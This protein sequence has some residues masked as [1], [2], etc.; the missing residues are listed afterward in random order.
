MLGNKVFFTVLLTLIAPTQ[1]TASKNYS[2]HEIEQVFAPHVMPDCP[3]KAFADSI[4]SRPEVCEKLFGHIEYEHLR[5]TKQFLRENGGLEL[6]SYARKVVSHP[7]LPHLLIKCGRQ[8]N[9]RTLCSNLSRV[10]EATKMRDCL[11][12]LGITNII[13]PNKW[14]YHLPGQGSQFC[15]ANYLIFAQKVAI[16]GRKRNKELL[17]NMPVERARD[18]LR[19]FIEVHYPD[20]SD[21][22]I[23]YLTDEETIA[24]VDTEG[25]NSSV[26]ANSPARRMLRI[27][28]PDTLRDVL[29]DE[30]R[31]EY[32]LKPFDE[33]YAEYM[34]R[35][36]EKKKK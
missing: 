8:R 29:T 36:V 10:D 20:I 27:I 3:T 4:F 31:A 6:D 5:E 28:K 32:K 7:Q 24:V 14:L 9:D 33:L 30:F 2:L 26:N 1:L 18:L 13:I 23:Y 11:Q 12:R 21:H 15:D 19:L 34:E 22:N 25:W 17:Y 16:S 35:E